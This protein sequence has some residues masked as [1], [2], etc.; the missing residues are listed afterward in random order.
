MRGAVAATIDD[1]M[2]VVVAV[3]VDIADPRFHTSHWGRWQEEDALMDVVAAAV[4]VVE[5]GV[6]VHIRCH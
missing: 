1:A 6:G 3:V 4:V 5:V 2:V